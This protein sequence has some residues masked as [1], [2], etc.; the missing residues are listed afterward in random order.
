M[1]ALCPVFRMSIPWIMTQKTQS[2]DIIATTGTYRPN[3]AVEVSLRS[4]GAWSAVCPVQVQ[5]WRRNTPEVA[6]F[7][8]EE[9]GRRE[10]LRADRRLDYQQ[11][12]GTSGGAKKLAEW[13]IRL[14]R[15]G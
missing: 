13:M 9:V 3:R 2:S 4:Q 8:T 6:L 5:E 1:V 15:I 12:I 7:C 10:R 14:E 11:L